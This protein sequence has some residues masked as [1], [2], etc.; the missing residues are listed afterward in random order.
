METLV[1]MGSAAS[2]VSAVF[3]SIFAVVTALTPNKR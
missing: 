1:I 2:I 3:L